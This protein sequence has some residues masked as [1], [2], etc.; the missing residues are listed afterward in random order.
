MDIELEKFRGNLLRSAANFVLEVASS[1]GP[2]GSGEIHG[3]DSTYKQNHWEDYRSKA[4][5]LN[6]LSTDVAKAYEAL[7]REGMRRLGVGIADLQRL[8]GL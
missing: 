7:I 2:L 5:E 6:N 1:T 3:F 4:S 8:G